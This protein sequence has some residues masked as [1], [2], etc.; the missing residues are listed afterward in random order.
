MQKGADQGDA[1]SQWLLGQL[2]RSG[3]TGKKEYEQAVKWFRA[4]ALQGH[5]EAQH[6]LGFMFRN[7]YGVK[8]DYEEALKWFRSATQQ[9]DLPSEI[10]IGEMYEKGQGVPQ[11]YAEALKRY[12]PNAETGNA[13]AQFNLGVLY[14]KGLGVPQNDIYAHMWLS[15]AARGSPRTA[16]G[17][18]A[19]KVRDSVAKRMDQAQLTEAQELATQ[20]WEKVWAKRRGKK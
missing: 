10:A 17:K 16:F 7:G 20:Q 14:S 8:L 2:Y 6:D 12:R 9:G 11:N 15:V 5:K 13:R 19:Q 3:A 1:K 18:E 4:S